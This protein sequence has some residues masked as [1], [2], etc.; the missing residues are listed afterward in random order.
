MLNPASHWESTLLTLPP[1]ATIAEGTQNFAN[2][3]GDEEDLVQA[4]ATGTPGI[5]AFARSAFA[6]E[7][8]ALSPTGGTGWATTIANKWKT[9]MEASVITPS[10]VT[11]PTWTMS[12]N[13]DTL[14]SPSAA[15]TITTIAAAASALEAE[16]LSVANIFQG[17]PDTATAQSGPGL[18]AQAFRNAMLACQFLCTGLA[19]GEPPVPVS[20]TFSA[21]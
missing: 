15:A 3:A 7:L 21:Q 17:S 18:V 4:G 19:P 2:W 10:T 1:V 8:L 14:T 12:G 13:K 9:A 20:L 11:S 16:L 6:A 5:L